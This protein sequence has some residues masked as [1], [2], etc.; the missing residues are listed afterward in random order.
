MI[1]FEK[2]DDHLDG[3]LALAG[4]TELLPLQQLVIKRIKQGGDAHI[5]G[6][7]L[8]GRS[9]AI[10]I[11]SVMKSPDTYEG[12][13]RV[14]IIAA[15][16]DRAHKLYNQMKEIYRRTEI[17]VELAHDKGKMIQE[18]NDIFDGTEMI[19]GT[20]KRLY[21]LFIQNGIH[22]SQLKL[23]IMDDAD[24]SCKDPMTA[25]YILRMNESLP[26]C[27]RLFFSSIDTPRMTAL[28]EE[29]LIGPVRLELEEEED[30]TDV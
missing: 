17:C 22:M 18:R 26:R 13:P 19:I 2:L 12:S 27:Q 7:A 3:T 28:M 20:P 24:I 16:V 11:A 6:A 8:S 29:I 4:I 14:L 23:F 15:D 21:D 25:T 5:V 1:S 30:S 9:T 10:T